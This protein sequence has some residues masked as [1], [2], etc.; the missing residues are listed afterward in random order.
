MNPEFLAPGGTHARPWHSASFAPSTQEVFGC[1]GF[2][3]RVSAPQCPPRVVFFFGGGP[4]HPPE[5]EPSLHLLPARGR[6]LLR[7][8]GAARRTKSRTAWVPLLLLALLALGLSGCL[9][10]PQNRRGKLADPMMSFSS[11][12]MDA[13]RKEKLQTT[14]EGAAGGNGRPAGGG[15]AC[16]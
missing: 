9:V 16:Q 4:D 5:R 15:C 2:S 11:G 12:R 13:Y 8:V 1:R 3:L 10:V 7:D 6:R 14:R